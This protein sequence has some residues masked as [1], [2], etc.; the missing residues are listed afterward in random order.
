ML[1]VRHESLLLAS[2]TVSFCLY[3]FIQIK[4]GSCLSMKVSVRTVSTGDWQAALT[5]STGLLEHHW[6]IELVVRTPLVFD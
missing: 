5:R 2:L 1:S 3:K 6:L 4:K